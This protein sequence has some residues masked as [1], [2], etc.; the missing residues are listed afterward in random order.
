MKRRSLLSIFCIT[1]GAVIGALGA[2]VL[3]M[4]LAEWWSF[5]NWNVVS[6]RYF[7]GHF[8][9]QF[10]NFIPIVLDLPLSFILLGIGGLIVAIGSKYLHKPKS[11][12][13]A[14]T[15]IN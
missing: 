5:G 6:I 14:P 2:L 13:K 1:T 8:H 10:S 9:I 15:Q 4:Q 7:L 11:S 3:F 12:E